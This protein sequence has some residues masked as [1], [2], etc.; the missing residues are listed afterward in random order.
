MK[1][2]IKIILIVTTL[3]LSV[4]KVQAEGKSVFTKILFLDQFDKGILDT[5]WRWIDPWDDST[6]NF[7]RHSWLEIMA[8]PGNDLQP[9]A[10]LNAPRLIRRMSG[11]FAIETKIS[12]S[13]SGSFLSGGLLIWKD[14]ENFIRF[15]RGTWGFDTIFLQKRE[16][17]LF[18][19][20]GDWFLSGNSIYLRMERIGSDFNTLFS[21]DGKTWN[22]AA[23]FE[24]DLSDPLYVGLHAIC[25]EPDF[26]PTAT[27]FDYFKILSTGKE[28]NYE[29][30]KQRKLSYDKLQ[31]LQRLE[32]KKLMERA[33]H[34]LSKT[35]SERNA[36]APKTVIT[37]PKTGLKFRKIFSEAKLDVIQNDRFITL[38]PDGNLL[39]AP[40][41]K[42]HWVVPLKE[43]N[44]PFRLTTQF[45]GEGML[46]SWSLDLSK[47]AFVISFTGDLW[48]MPI[49]PETGRSTGSPEKIF[50][51]TGEWADKYSRPSW[52]PDGEKLAFMSKRSG[53]LDI[54]VIPAKGGAPVQLTADPKKE[55]YPAWSPDGKTIAFNRYRESLPEKPIS[56][57]IWLIPAEATTPRPP[58]LRGT[59]EKLIEDV[60]DWSYPVWSSDG[61]YIAFFRSRS[62][63]DEGIYIFRLSDRREFK[64][65]EKYPKE[66]S[67]TLGWSKDSQKVLFFGSGYEYQSAL[68]LVS[69]YGGPWVELGK[70]LEFNTDIQS[71]SKDGKTIVTLGSTSDLG[72]WIIPTVGG[73]PA[74]IKIDTKSKITKFPYYPISPDL[75]KLAFI[76]EDLPSSEAKGSSLWIVEISIEDLK[77]TGSAVKIA[78]QLK[79]TTGTH[80]SYYFTSWSPDSKKIAFHSIKSGNVDIWVASVDGKELIQ[81]TD[82]PEDETETYYHAPAAPVWSP[83][84]KT[85]AYISQAGI[86]LIPASGG[87][88]QELVKEAW[89]PAWS[90]D[91]KELGFIGKSHISVITLET[92]AVRNL[93]DLVAHSL[94]AE[95]SWDLSWSPDGKNLAFFSYKNPNYRLW[96]VPAK[97]GELLE[98]AKNDPGDKFYLYWSPDGKKLSYASYRAVRVRTGAIWEANVEEL[99]SKMD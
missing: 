56:S 44:D 31:S 87:K 47:F 88:P 95:R 46:G 72:C 92:G 83:D 98:L 90:P 39:F 69:A 86:W 34:V 38:S 63:K 84:G 19:H 85:L 57:D 13:Q 7:P 76:G 80:P 70:G 14:E 18:Q 45:T 10:N 25:F 60:N 24:C 77:T 62:K 61:K 43:G 40:W 99:L 3:I 82:N 12:K 93:V 97:G 23:K 66:I 2:D 49:S 11:D 28:K 36:F 6:L 64:V 27:E 42:E 33:N 78:D 51:E 50:D 55:S 94:D 16:D 52:S 17:G 4:A 21:S 58:F 89:D 8:T 26:P 48:M 79:R 96:V 37:D 29:V 5:G 53:N 67:W 65:I 59:A 75:Q 22:E 32:D 74:K 71:W 20:V 30:K 68:K 15:D 35:A 54:W 91:G 81:L 73:A 41:E 1:R 9:K